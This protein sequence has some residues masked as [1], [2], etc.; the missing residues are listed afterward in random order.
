MT[1]VN[2]DALS[3]RALLKRIARNAEKLAAADNLYDER[4]ALFRAA[5][6]R[7]TPIRYGDIADAA[8]LSKDATF[9]VL[10]VARRRDAATPNNHRKETVRAR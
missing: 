8:G 2:L 1:T 3:A 6:N 5:R 10:R 7:P 9:K 4:L